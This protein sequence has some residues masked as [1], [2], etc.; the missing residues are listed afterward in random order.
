MFKKTLCI[1][2]LIF[3][4]SCKE[5]NSN[6]E[7]NKPTNTQPENLKDDEDVQPI[8]KTEKYTKWNLKIGQ[9]HLSVTSFGACT[10]SAQCEF[11]DFTLVQ[12]K[13][14]KI[15][16][17][18]KFPADF[19]FKTQLQEISPRIIVIKSWQTS[20]ED[21][22][23]YEN[24]FHKNLERLSE[25]AVKLELQENFDLQRYKAVKA[26]QHHLQTSRCTQNY[27]VQN[28]KSLCPLTDGNMNITNSSMDIL[29]SMATTGLITSV[30]YDLEA[31]QIVSLAT[32]LET[33]LFPK[34]LHGFG[35]GFNTYLSS[36]NVLL[37]SDVVEFNS[38]SPQYS[39]NLRYIAGKCEQLY[40]ERA[41]KD[42]RGD[43]R[44]T[45]SLDMNPLWEKDIS[46]KLVQT[47]Q[48]PY[49]DWKLNTYSYN[50]PIIHLEL[51]ES[52]LPDLFFTDNFMNNQLYR[53]GSCESL[54]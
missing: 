5:D 52:D 15:F 14:R 11:E 46:E 30:Q 6:S 13:D 4:L 47:L 2:L 39:T 41:S 1:I 45:T 3:A 43:H 16:S 48:I 24:I 7:F 28:F 10:G 50:E 12:Y 38:V 33:T 21:F 8:R 37:P 44:S 42:S 25:D 54:F 32:F 9:H 18:R 36:T 27:L 51:L 31:D 40:K 26:A 29:A 23:T 20:S 34:L 49:N 35:K 19:D 53:G 22:A 17:N